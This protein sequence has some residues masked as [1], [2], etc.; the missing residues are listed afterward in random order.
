MHKMS[1]GIEKHSV[2]M[3]G[4]ANGSLY[5]RYATD[6]LQRIDF[7]RKTIG[8]KVADRAGAGTLRWMGW[9]DQRAF[10]CTRSQHETV[11][12]RSPDNDRNPLPL[13][14]SGLTSHPSPTRGAI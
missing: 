11:H 5:A 3:V 14:E 6:V 10:V 4:C 13:G 8:V 7:L 9:H 1:S 2:Y 12:L